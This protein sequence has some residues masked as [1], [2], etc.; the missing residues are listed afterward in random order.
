MLLLQSPGLRSLQNSGTPARVFTER[1][2]GLARVK[3]RQYAHDLQGRAIGLSK[4][5]A[6]SLP[7]D[8]ALVTSRLMAVEGKVRQ[9][10]KFSDRQRERI[11]RMPRAP[12]GPS[13]LSARSAGNPPGTHCD[14]SRNNSNRST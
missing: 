13:P 7:V 3:D 10:A 4:L 2:G 12:E 14:N 9:V 5:I 1:K 6:G 11:S 8:E